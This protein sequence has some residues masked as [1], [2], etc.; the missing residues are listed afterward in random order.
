MTPPEKFLKK[1]LPCSKHDKFLDEMFLLVQEGFSA[2]TEKLIEAIVR[3]IKT[4]KL[5]KSDK[6]T[7]LKLLGAGKT[8][9][10]TGEIPRVELDLSF[11]KNL[12]DK[13][14]LALKWMLLGKSAGKEVARAVE[15]LGLKTIL[16]TGTIF[17]TFLH[18]IDQQRNFY[19]DLTG[20]KPPK[21][22]D[23]ALRYSLDFVNERTGKWA[24][25]SLL[26]YRNKLLQDLQDRIENFNQDNIGAVHES[27]HDLLEEKGIVESQIKTIEQKQELVRDAMKG[28]IEKK[29]SLVQM[30]QSLKDITQDYG[31]DWDRLVNTEF[32]MA[33]GAGTHLAVQEV[34]GG[35]DSEML[36]ANVNVKDT[37][38]C[39]ECESWSRRANGDFK[40]YRLS[41]I[42]PVGYNIAKKRQDWHLTAAT[43]HPNC[44]PHWTNVLTVDGWKPITELN[45]TEK[46]FS[47]NLETGEGEWV[48]IKEIIKFEQATITTYQNK[49]FELSCA[50]NHDH[51]ISTPHLR[52]KHIRNNQDIPSSS[53]FCLSLSKWTGQNSDFIYIGNNKYSSSVFA[54]FMA[55]FLSEGSV[56]LTEKNQHQIKISQTKHKTEFADICRE[57]FEVVW[58]G[59]EA[60]FMPIKDPDL[61]SYFRQFG[62]SWE[63]FI[64][65]E[66]KKMNRDNLELFL[67]Y[68]A[69]GDGSIRHKKSKYEKFKDINFRPNYYF[70][71]S[72]AKMMSDLCQLLLKVGAG[73]SITPPGKP[74]ICSHRNGDYLTK[75]PC[76]IITRKNRLKSQIKSLQKQEVMYNDF[77]YGVELDKNHT[78]FVEQRGNVFLTGNCRCTL[79]YIPKGWTVDTRGILRKL[80]PDEKLTIERSTGLLG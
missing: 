52:S 34:F 32:G 59:K 23:E 49:W 62:Y 65:I 50:N 35:E 13:Y 2:V 48:G 18:A 39:D 73:V 68:F 78:L 45:K 60:I 54:K 20:K 28:V 26:I 55:I 70:F 72:S 9:G 30:K 7:V 4:E 41:D 53:A 67:H 3:Q 37:R 38:C 17:G 29:M 14:M 5:A 31:K 63:K 16:P 8:R 12:I 47:E 76:W 58:E 80:E 57:M 21:I 24:D 42:K 46:V 6:E 40:I 15:E 61:I 69:M 25:Q 22:Q 11:T 74:K 56:S 19:L 44:L 51:V 27:Y 75:H 71:T 79:V 10:F 33:T 36:V 66:I 1:D 43:H 77:V 64:P